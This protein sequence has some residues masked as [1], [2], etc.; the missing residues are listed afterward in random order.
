MNS[1]T[2]FQ[3]TISVMFL[4]VFLGYCLYTLAYI[5][6]GRSVIDERLKR[7]GSVAGQSGELR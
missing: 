5:F 7:Y 1:L 2:I 6:S 4:I 3:I